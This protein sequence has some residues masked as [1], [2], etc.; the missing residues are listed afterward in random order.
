MLACLHIQDAI[1]TVRNIIFQPNNSLFKVDNER[2]VQCC[3]LL[4]SLAFKHNFKPGD[5]FR[6]ATTMR[7]NGSCRI[8]PER[9][10]ERETAECLENKISWRQKG[11][12]IIRTRIS[13]CM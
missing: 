2:A 8:G 10:R 13:V 4:S 1:S 9:E 5:M 3:L 6:Q 11:G 7:D 12:M